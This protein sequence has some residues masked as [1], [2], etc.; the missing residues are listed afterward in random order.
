MKQKVK[1]LNK[2]SID[3]IDYEFEKKRLESQLKDKI[4]SLG[5]SLDYINTLNKKKNK[6]KKEQIILDSFI[7]I[8][9]EYSEGIEYL[10]EYKTLVS[11]PIPDN[12]SDIDQIVPYYE[13][14]GEEIHMF[15][16]IVKND[17]NRIF[18]KIKLLKKQL[19]DGDYKILKCY[20]SDML[21]RKYPY[22]LES[23][24]NERNEIRKEIND[25]QN[26]IP[27]EEKISL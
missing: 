19:S 2:Y 7:A 27:N 3:A 17:S 11:S 18:E 8:E 16:E 24:V 26:L 13:E 22:D 14:I 5:V 21:G 10:N 6:T 9:K 15:W 4:E 1:I 25:L 23:L 12:V 20:E